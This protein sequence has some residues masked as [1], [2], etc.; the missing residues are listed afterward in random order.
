MLFKTHIWHV[1]L[2]Q[3]PGTAVVVQSGTE[4]L[5]V[6]DRSDVGARPLGRVNQPLMSVLLL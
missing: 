1:Y 2:L 6:I 4:R 3:V 5:E